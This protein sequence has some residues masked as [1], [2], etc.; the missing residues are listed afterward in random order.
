MPNEATQSLLRTLEPLHHQGRLNQMIAL[1]RTL[2]AASTV[3]ELEGGKLYER[4]LALMTCYT[5][6]DQQHVLRALSDPSKF[7][8]G[9]AIKLVAIVLEDDVLNLALER[10]PAQARRAMLCIWIRRGRAQ[11]PVDAFVQTLARDADHTPLIEM[12]SLASPETVRSH[13]NAM[14]LASASDW[15][16]LAK[17]H[18]EL[19]AETLEARAATLTEADARLTWLVN[20]VLPHLTQCNPQRA[21]SL[22]RTMMT[23]TSLTRLAIQGLLNRLPNDT[24]ELLLQSDDNPRLSLQNHTQLLT[25]SLLFAMHDQHRDVIGWGGRWLKH[26]PPEARAAIYERIVKFD[27]APVNPAALQWIPT[28][29]RVREARRHLIMVS[30]AG[31]AAQ[32]LQYAGFLPWAEAREVL[33]ETIRHPKP[34]VRM[35]GIAALIHSARFDRS[36]RNDVLEFVRERKFEQDPVRV[37]MLNALN[38]LPPAAWESTHLEP[39]GQIL[40]DAL[41]AADLSNSSVYA[42]QQLVRNLLPFQP[43]WASPWIETISRERHQVHLH[44]IEP[45]LSKTALQ[46]LSAPLEQSCQRLMKSRRDHLVLIAMALGCHVRK[47]PWLLE[48]LETI[49]QDKTGLTSA[50]LNVIKQHDPQRFARSVPKLIKA[51]PSWGTQPMVYQHLHRYRQDLIAPYLEPKHYGGQHRTGREPFLLPVT[52]GFRRWNPTQHQR[53]V[54]TLEK[55]LDESERETPALFT[56]IQQLAA[57]PDAPTARIERLAA[58][59]NTR[60][61]LRDHALRSLGRLDEGRGLPMLL[62]ALNDGRDRIAIYAVRQLLM[63]MPRAQALRL[64]RQTSLTRVAVAKEIMRLIGDLGGEEA[65]QTLLE[66]E[67]QPL[68]RDVRVALLRG[69][70][71]HLEHEQ[72]WA[73]LNRAATD[74]DAAIADGVIRIPTERL[75]SA[76]Q[77]KLIALISLLLEHPDVQVRLNTLERCQALPVNDNERT[78]LPKLLNALHSVIQIEASSAAQAIFGTYSNQDAPILRT[79]L[80][81]LLPNRRSLETLCAALLRAIRQ[82]PKRLQASARIVIDILNTDPMTTKLQLGIVIAALPWNEIKTHLET[83][84]NNGHLHAD[85]LGHAIQTI[86]QHPQRT[87]DLNALE[88]LE[89]T[90]HDHPHEHLR[91]LALSIL[92]GIANR[93]GWNSSR[94]EHLRTY[95]Q[96]PSV[97]VASAAQFTLPNAELEEVGG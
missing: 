86:T 12:L 63:T 22:V 95:R 18:P 59:G 14:D 93:D 84:T 66:F 89:R 49:S 10:V 32:R 87:S 27:V 82:N 28:N 57:I 21:L 36:R 75:S 83:L 54:W 44:G 23:S 53:F 90:W 5:S 31:D 79:A 15:A 30:L 7:I 96:D 29:L 58:I 64:L 4:Q 39:L 56:A 62:E 1:G 26:Y 17:H 47:L 34:D 55:R 3:A 19:V 41:D 71:N 52:D 91:R 37:V 67:P 76:T 20:A 13:L 69:L 51:D 48:L 92:T 61:A 9:L 24:S 16:R 11:A 77:P 2:D 78:L 81:P 65:Y 33:D 80:Q 73:I 42:I 85:A 88:Q 35:I 72:T 6:R 8:R 68:H 25:P 97:L 43:D 45:R 74:E 46:Q 70:W 60:L 38:Q 40:R 50:A 94:L